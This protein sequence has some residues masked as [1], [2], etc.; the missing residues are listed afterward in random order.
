M[1]KYLHLIKTVEELVGK[2]YGEDRYLAN[3]YE[4]PWTS[5]TTPRPT[6]TVDGKTYKF[7]GIFDAL[8]SVDE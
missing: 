1:A 4:E 7:D 6:I 3:E 2:Y 5:V 8:D